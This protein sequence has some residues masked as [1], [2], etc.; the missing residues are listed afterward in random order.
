M[1]RNAMATN[2]MS[3]VILIDYD[4]DMT[5][6][7]NFCFSASVFQ[8]LLNCANREKINREKGVWRNGIERFVAFFHRFSLRICVKIV[9]SHHDK[10]AIDSRWSWEKKDQIV[11]WSSFSLQFFFSSSLLLAIQIYLHR[12]SAWFTQVNQRKWHFCMYGGYYY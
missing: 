7:F 12:L 11:A 5:F 4:I 6:A 2:P 1:D 10:T 3:R 8:W 9:P